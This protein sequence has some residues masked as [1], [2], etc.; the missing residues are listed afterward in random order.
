VSN[1]A[2]LDPNA[3][4]VAEGEA[5]VGAGDASAE[6]ALEQ[7]ERWASDPEQRVIVV[8]GS[9]PIAS[10]L[11]GVFAA[12]L[13]ERFRVVR[14]SD[15]RADPDT[16]ARRV[17]DSLGEIDDER[18]RA[19]FARVIHEPRA[20]PLLLLVDDAEVLSARSEMW[21]F[22]LVRR[23]AGALRVALAL[24]EPRPASEL[25]AAFSASTEVVPIDAPARI[26]ARSGGGRVARERAAAAQARREERSSFE[27]STG[28]ASGEGAALVPAEKERAQPARPKPRP[29]APSP[30][31]ARKSPPPPEPA[32]RDSLLRWLLL[33]GALAA[34]FVAGF[35]T[36]ELLQMVRGGGGAAGT[37]VQAAIPAAAVPAARAP[38]SEREPPA[39][40]SAP[41]RETAA[42]AP[43]APAPSP[44]AAA[45]PAPAPPEPPAVAAQ[46]V[47]SPPPAEPSQEQAS[48]PPREAEPSLEAAPAEA[49]PAPPPAREER[50]RARAATRPAGPAPV[51]F[52]V[53]AEPGTEITVDGRA[54]GAAPVEEIELERGPHHLVARLPDGRVVERVVDV[55]GSR[56]DVRLR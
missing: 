24:A 44:A 11:L 48:A 1:D 16:I 39:V 15:P 12:G 52:K 7:L 45:L 3:Q 37:A 46:P 6:R 2:E 54:L 40:A 55:Q 35:V 33:P 18:P 38:D 42:P 47:A 53:S 32:R 29:R 25:A 14:L 19:A 23:S 22:D 34:C 49:P 27:E 17:L 9:A 10:S 26:Q 20:A 5:D 8:C 50:R 51:P 21:L 28:S 41:P 36:S 56:Y 31:A 13:G 30:S 4:P 43:L